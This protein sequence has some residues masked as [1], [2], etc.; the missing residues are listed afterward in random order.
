MDQ[1]NNISIAAYT[2]AVES[3]RRLKCRVY[4]DNIGLLK[5]MEIRVGDLGLFLSVDDART[6]AMRVLAAI[7]EAVAA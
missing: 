3:Q 1:I 6:L 4:N 5:R 7:D 2:V